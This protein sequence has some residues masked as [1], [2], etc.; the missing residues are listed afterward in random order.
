MKTAYLVAGLA[1]GDEG[2][3]SIVDSLVRQHKASLVVRYNGGAQAAH[4]VIS[5]EGQHHTFAQFGSGT[6]AGARTH[7]SRHVLIEP[8]SMMNEAKHLFKLKVPID[9]W[10]YTTIDEKALI[11]T[12]FQKAANRIIEYMRAGKHHGTC[13]MGIGQTRGDYL[14]HG[15]EVLFAGDLISEKTTKEKLCFIQHISLKQTFELLSDKDVP[16]ALSE[17]AY[18]LTS[19]QAINQIWEQYNLWPGRVV[20]ADYL[21][22][23]LSQ[24]SDVVF[25]GAQGVLLDE[26]FGFAPHNTWTDI[27][28]NNANELLANARFEGRVERIGVLRSYF[29]RHG[30]GPFPTEDISMNY[31]EPHNNSSGFQGAFRQG[32]FDSDLALYALRA[33]GGI[34]TLALNHLDVTPCLAFSLGNSRLKQ[35]FIT[36]IQ[37]SL[38]AKNLILGFG[39]TAEDK[40]YGASNDATYNDDNLRRSTCCR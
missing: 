40:Y 20:T 18:L 12:P 14:K 2:K 13:G 25:E 10:S 26:K 23:L 27:T 30:A 31:P 11:I 36:S 21:T 3:G 24:N 22:S 29:T 7:L 5:P 8:I 17:S 16:E 32:Q 39:P 28:F 38:F 33:I 4:N 19:K 15:D 37:D 34:D 35:L 6:L 1:F 9:V